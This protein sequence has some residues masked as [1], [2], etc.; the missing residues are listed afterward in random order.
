MIHEQYQPGVTHLDDIEELYDILVLQV[1]KD[2]CLFVSLENLI[3]LEDSRVDG[4]DRV[5]FLGDDMLP[6]KHLA[7]TPLPKLL[8]FME[9]LHVEVIVKVSA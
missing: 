6:E 9:Q 1:L 8:D 5:L 7:E 4:F 3:R 2:L